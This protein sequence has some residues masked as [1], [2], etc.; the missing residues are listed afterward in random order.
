[1]KLGVFLKHMARAD[2]K[3]NQGDGSHVVFN[4]VISLLQP[5]I[6]ILVKYLG[7]LHHLGVEWMPV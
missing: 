2:G 6:L 3:T 5:F 1:M 4:N 7:E